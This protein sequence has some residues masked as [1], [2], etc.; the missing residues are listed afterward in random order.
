[1]IVLMPLEYRDGATTLAV[2]RGRRRGAAL[3]TRRAASACGSTRPV[4]P[5]PGP[6]ERSRRRTVRSAPARCPAERCREGVPGGRPADP[7]AG[8]RGVAT[9]RARGARPGRDP[10]GGSHR[11]HVVARRGS[12]LVPAIPPRAAGRRAAAQS[13]ALAGTGPGG[14]L[15]P[16]GCGLRLQHAEV[17]PGTGS[18]PG[19]LTKARAC[20]AQGA[21]P[22]ETEE[23]PPARPDRERLR[24][25][26]A[27]PESGLLRPPHASLLTRAP[28]GS[29]NRPGSRG[30]GHLAGPRR[31]QAGSRVRQRRDALAVPQRR[32]AAAGRGP[33]ST[34]RVLSHLAEGEHLALAGEIR[35]R[36][37]ATTGC[38]CSGEPH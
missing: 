17:R 31:L 12:R 26:P 4:P 36:R 16:L 27:A 2:L 7:S 33:A 38:A 10:A 37:A 24:L 15:R 34:D 3:R 28:E 9:R 6:G 25:V 14:S 11:E 29:T 22:D 19:R 1:M 21:C 35:E 13:V 8:Q 30:S 18:S 23:P 32:R 20:R 5:D